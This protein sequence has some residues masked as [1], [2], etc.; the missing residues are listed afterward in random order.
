MKVDS[1][2]AN[3]GL[4]LAI[5]GAGV[6]ASFQVGKTPPSL[7]LI[8]SELGLT[9]VTAGWVISILN[10]VGALSGL[11][12]GTVA[13]LL[14]RRRILLAGLLFL[15]LGS[16]LG[17]LAPNAVM[18]LVSR[19]IEGVG[20]ILVIV[21]GPALIIGIT[22]PRSIRQALGLWAGFMPTGTSLMM[23]LSPL[24]LENVGW[25]GL[26][27]VNTGLILAYCIFLARI[28]SGIGGS[29]F[30]GGDRIK[31]VWRDIR[32]TLSRP[33]PA[34][35]A[36]TFTLYALQFMAVIG[37]LPTL[38]IDELGLSPS[39]AA[40]LAALV[41][42]MNAPGNMLGGWLLQ[43]G[44]RRVSLLCLASLAMGL[45]GLGIY[46]GA[47]GGVARF[48]LGLVFSG[49]GGIIPACLISGVQVHAPRPGLM[50]TTSGLTMQGGS[51][52]SLLGPPALAVVVSA[53][54][55]WSGAPYLLVGAASAG[56]GLSL[57]LGRLEARL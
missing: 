4:I 23:L 10:L 43:R 19:F 6:A 34:I 55:G 40:M 54:G 25:R 45:C 47:L 29:P 17:G 11:V 20:Y 44:L 41:A 9:L 39:S 8:R 12:S 35:L 36:V 42:F 52:G 56:I 57:Y 3:W 49:V 24:I 1:E 14:G 15:C 51:V 21:T 26:W 50:A 37:F 46:S 13:D 5:F 27:L 22:P 32:M 38:L 53:A 31:T 18:L 2:A 7:P 16:L 33:G 30:S 48:L 28:T